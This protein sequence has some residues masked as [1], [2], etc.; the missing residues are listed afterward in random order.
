[1]FGEVIDNVS[2]DCTEYLNRT[3]WQTIA[4]NPPEE[5]SRLSFYSDLGFRV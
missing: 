2:I 5:A 1:M 3:N 4:Q